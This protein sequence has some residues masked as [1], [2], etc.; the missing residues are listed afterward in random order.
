MRERRPD[1]RDGSTALVDGGLV[2]H[3]VDPGGEPG[4][5][6][7]VVRHEISHESP[8]TRA[9]F[10]G[11][12]SRPDD[13]NGTRAGKV[14]P[15]LVIE[16]RDGVGRV[17]Q[18]FRV[19]DRTMDPDAESVQTGFVESLLDKRGALARI[20]WR[21]EVRR[22]AARVAGELFRKRLERGAGPGP[23]RLVGT[24]LVEG[25]DGALPEVRVVE[26]Q[27]KRHRLPPQGRWVRGYTALG[28][29]SYRIPGSGHRP[30]LGKAMDSS[31]LRSFPEYTPYPLPPP[32]A[33][34]PNRPSPLRFGWRRGLRWAS[35]R[36]TAPT[37]PPN[38]S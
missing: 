2:G 38:P 32:I 19:L 31:A 25:R 28:D 26:V 33:R 24:H 13:G 11:R 17:A 16:H 21:D 18:L 23:E 10:A 22:N 29:P 6:G 37:P 4:D 8:R 36:W 15:P 35:H 7:E 14:P 5:D 12:L 27:F 9:P 30:C 34:V 20:T 1:D 3:P